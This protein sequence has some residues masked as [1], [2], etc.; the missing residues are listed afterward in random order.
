MGGRSTGVVIKSILPGGIADKD[1]RLQSGDHVI[2]IGEVNLRGFS[3]EQVAAVLR[4]TGSNVG[5][6]P[7]FSLSNFIQFPSQVKMVVARSIDPGSIDTDT[8]QYGGPVVPTRILT[9]PEELDR[10]LLMHEPNLVEN[11]FQDNQEIVLKKQE[12]INNNNNNNNNNNY[13]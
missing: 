11:S 6:F 5:Y 1:G 8:Y 10:Q 7:P 12:I 2:Q 9:D 3:A 13:R 4:Q